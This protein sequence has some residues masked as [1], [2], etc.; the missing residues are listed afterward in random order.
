[1][2]FNTTKFKNIKIIHKYGKE[3]DNKKEFSWWGQQ[4]LLL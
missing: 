1:M 2:G 4:E 3:K